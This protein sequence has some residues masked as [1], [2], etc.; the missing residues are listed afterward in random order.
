MNKATEEK[1]MQFINVC[2]FDMERKAMSTTQFIGEIEEF[3]I[4]NPQIS[5]E[6]ID[7][8]KIVATKFS[9]NVIQKRIFVASVFRLLK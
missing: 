1:L 2:R 4:G 5:L 7:S 8:V 3:A 9:S 6:R